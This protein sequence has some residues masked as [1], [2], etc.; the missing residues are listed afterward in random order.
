[1]LLKIHIII[2]F[3]LVQVLSGC[4]QMRSGSYSETRNKECL[5]VPPNNVDEKIK[6]S[7]LIK[8]IKLKTLHIDFIDN[9]YG[10][11]DSLVLKVEQPINWSNQIL[12]MYYQGKPM[13]QKRLLKK[14]DKFEFFAEI[15]ECLDDEW[16]FLR[17]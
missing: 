9:S 17:N 14:R 6:F 15:P 4:A 16:L 1:M 2:S 8:D 3:I 7:F 12:E 10:Y 13:L 5:K 11:F